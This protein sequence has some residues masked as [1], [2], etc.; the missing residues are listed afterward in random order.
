MS[1]KQKKETAPAD[2]GSRIT[3]NRPTVN[4]GRVNHTKENVRS[5]TNQN[6][7]S[8]VKEVKFSAGAVQK[9][10]AK[11]KIDFQKE[12]PL[13]ENSEKNTENGFFKSV[14]IRLKDES[15]GGFFSGKKGNRPASRML[16]CGSVDIPLLMIFII[17]AVYGLIMVFS[18]S[19]AYA[20]SKDENS[21][22]FIKKQMIY[23]GLGAILAGIIIWLYDRVLNMG[24]VPKVVL[25]YFAV[26]ICML[27]LIFVPG[28]GIMEGETK[29]W[30]DLKVIS[31]Q[32]SEFAKGA[33]ILMLAL[34][35]TKY[36]KKLGREK[37]WNGLLLGS[38]IPYAMSAVIILLV[39]LENHTSGTII[40][41][42]IAIMM[43]F[44]GERKHIFTVGALVLGLTVVIVAITYLMQFDTTEKKAEAP[45]LVNKIVTHYSWKRIEIWLRPED[46]SIRDELW[47][48]T[49]GIYA[50]GSGGFMG[51]GFGQSRQKHLFV[52][53]PQNDFI[54]TIVCE[55]MGLVGAVIV[56]VLFAALIWR[57]VKVG[58][59]IPD[60][61]SRLAVWGL[62]ASI[63]MQ[64][65]LNIGVVTAILPNTGISLPFFSYGGSSII[66]LMIEVGIIL[67]LSRYAVK[68][69]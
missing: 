41:G 25:I 14:G 6:V 47:Q 36:E 49:Q 5:A 59:K 48:T 60:T 31:L 62:T 1:E 24:L 33:L 64:A 52:S 2:S 17:L 39:F 28:F 45:E 19:Y 42:L 38:F 68:D 22:S 9:E 23:F 58:A 27:V 54:F 12:S 4:I 51:V 53:Q 15:F 10:S 63:G 56:I 66:S 65:F 29:R 57:G 34:Y 8:A 61:F 55:E 3:V 20:Y 37:G 67:A 11:E 40:L 50:I 26:A 16:E 32:P 35:F 21:Y 44:F 46:F 13:Q 18:A 7:K 30:L 43:V 69:N